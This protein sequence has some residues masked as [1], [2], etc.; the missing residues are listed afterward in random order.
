M[1]NISNEP[2]DWG[3]GHRM[4]QYD[5]DELEVRKVRALERIADALDGHKTSK[6]SGNV[7]DQPEA[8]RVSKPQVS[9]GADSY[10]DIFKIR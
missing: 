2:R 8:K 10:F 3:G 6:W 1:A 9:K 4:T 7:S 5:M